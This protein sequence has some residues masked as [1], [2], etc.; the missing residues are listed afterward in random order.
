MPFGDDNPYK[1]NGKELDSQTGLYYYG[2]RYYDPQRSF[3]LSV[4]PL[5]EITMS[6]Y[7][8]TWNDPVNYTD[9]TGRIGD[10]G[11]TNPDSI[12]H[13]LTWSKAHRNAER[14]ANTMRYG[15]NDVSMYKHNYGDWSR[16]FNRWS[17]YSF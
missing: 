2:A 17:F 7:A 5:V 11:G 8:Y 1:F 14:Y 12:W 6:P 15:S 9:P 13:K 16:K 3:W 4:D 10:P